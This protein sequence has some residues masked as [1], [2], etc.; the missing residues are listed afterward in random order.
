MLSLQAALEVTEPSAKH[1]V[2]CPRD[3]FGETAKVKTSTLVEP[4]T[5]DARAQDKI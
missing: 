4:L 1:P 5:A 2:L 3:A